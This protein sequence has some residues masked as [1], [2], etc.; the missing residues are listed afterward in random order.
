MGFR[1][2]IKGLA[3]T[4][5]DI[6]GV[7]VDVAKDSLVKAETEGPEAGPGGTDA[8]SAKKNPVPTQKAD[9][10]PQ[11]LMWD[12]FS[13]IE[14]LGYKDRPSQMTYYTLKSMVWRTPVVHAVI[15]TRINQIASFA[16]PQHD[17]YQVGFRL[18]LRDSEKEP[19]RIER[20][21]MR[22]MEALVIRTGVT[23]NPRGRDNFET[24]LR[25]ISWDTLVLDQ[26]NFEV[27][28]NRK[29]TPAEWY[30]VDASTIRLA[31]SASTYMDEDMT[32]AVRF[33]QIY[34]GQ[35]IAEFTQEEMCFA[36][37]NPR[38]D[39]RVFG[40]GT[41]EL[42]MLISTV[43]SLLWAWEYNQRFFSQGSAAKGILNFKGAIP[44]TM[45]QQFRRQWYQMISGVENA[46]RTPVT[47]AE[48]LQ[49]INMQQ[50]SRDM[51]YNAWMDFLIKV[52]CSMY[53]MDP[54][55][56]NFKYGNTGQRTGLQ[57][58]NNK[59]KVTESKERGLRPL[60]RFIAEQM[61]QSIIWPINEAFE[62]DFVGLDA[63]TRD[64]MAD[65][66]KKRVQ[67]VMTVDEIRAEDDKPPLPDGKG[68][69]ILDSNWLQFS[70][71]KDGLGM[72]D[73]FGAGAGDGDMGE[74]EADDQ[75]GNGNGEDKDEKDDGYDKLLS[76][77]DKKNGGN[78]NNK[79]K[80]NPK[81]GSKTK[82]EDKLAASLS[83]KV[84]VNIDL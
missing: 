48:D 79:G 72:D 10:D 7:V 78:G 49:W 33:V 52:A 62:F 73:G 40:Y 39:I 75:P 8:D 46:W 70:Q 53:Q 42:E 41:S 67:T 23:D 13:I 81:P 56:V 21:W 60:L 45:L 1:D 32:D 34:D 17:R 74:G 19:T 43:T 6:A 37:R 65:L 66:N 76:P 36:V 82:K 14:Q 64:Q 24:F 47:N 25:K 5:L 59:E 69:C 61:N 80:P 35:V 28:P 4:A 3:S 51:E 38:T 11:S 31:D 12:P 54:I 22:Q 83:G 68:E 44:Q 9:Q 16:K 15:Q 50:S 27:V 26:L 71:Q 63:L 58:G 55:E 18:K 30:A 2:N 29:G 57:E 77:F 84:L 20:Q